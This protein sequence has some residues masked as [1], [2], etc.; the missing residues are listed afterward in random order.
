MDAFYL[1]QER[2]FRD[3]YK[4]AQAK[5][6]QVLEIDPYGYESGVKGLI[7]SIFSRSV[8]PFHSVVVIVAIVAGV[9]AWVSGQQ[10]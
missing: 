10:G 3:M 1:G 7:G 2:H 5:K 4:D 6:I 9:I 8:W